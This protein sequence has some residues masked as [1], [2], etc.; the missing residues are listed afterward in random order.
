MY[1]FNRVKPYKV[2]GV[3]LWELHSDN[4]R[5][6]NMVQQYPNYSYSQY[7]C[8]WLL[9]MEF[10]QSGLRSFAGGTRKQQDILIE[11]LEMWLAVQYLYKVFMEYYF[12][13]LL[14]IV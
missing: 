9:L 14:T 7:H 3:V 6:N 12:V 10:A 13:N 1:H 11:G 8:W 5:K 2:F 4:Y